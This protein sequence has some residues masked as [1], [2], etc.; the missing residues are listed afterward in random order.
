MNHTSEFIQ[1]K[2]IANVK[3]MNLK[4]MSSR[5]SGIT[6]EVSELQKKF[7]RYVLQV[8]KYMT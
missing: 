4:K 5:F 8:E 6:E 2:K 3:L 7:S 1:M